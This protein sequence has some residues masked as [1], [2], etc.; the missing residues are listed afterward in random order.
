MHARGLRFLYGLGRLA[1][2]ALL[3]IGPG[4]PSVDHVLGADRA[5]ASD[6]RLPAPVG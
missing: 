4:T 1:P 3:L 2:L 6:D 5:G